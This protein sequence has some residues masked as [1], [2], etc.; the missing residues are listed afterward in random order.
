MKTQTIKVKLRDGEMGAYLAFPD[1]TPSGAIIAIMEI[2]G[3]NDTMRRHT[4]SPRPASS[5][6]CRT[7]SGGRSRGS[8]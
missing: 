6:W 4:N 5:A 7:C 2:W 1:R 3:V 8:S